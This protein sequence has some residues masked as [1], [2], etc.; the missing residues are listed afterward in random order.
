MLSF[1]CSDRCGV[2]HGEG[3]H[4]FQNNR[5]S[6]LTP[7]SFNEN[8]IFHCN[9][10]QNGKRS[11]QM[12]PQSHYRIYQ[13]P[14]SLKSSHLPLQSLRH[15]V[16]N[17]HVNCCQNI[18]DNVVPNSPAASYK[19]GE[20]SVSGESGSLTPTSPPTSSPPLVPKSPTDHQSTRLVHNGIN[21]NLAQTSLPPSHF[22]H[23]PPHMHPHPTAA[24]P[25][26]VPPQPMPQ[27][28]L[29][30]Q[31][32]P[33]NAQIDPDQMFILSGKHCW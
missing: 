18:G 23:Y 8:H 25:Q 27:L 11:A 5:T 31:G 32:L 26:V 24:G 16:V 13:G 2:R 1:T 21:P 30:W 28:N 19:H 29:V 6:N 7:R 3:S 4:Q 17:E 15:Q 12:Q 10:N 14:Q 33:A 20:E 22:N 9:N